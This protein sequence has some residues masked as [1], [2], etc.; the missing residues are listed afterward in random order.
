MRP[1]CLMFLVGV[2]GGC[3][4]DP[5]APA[6]DASTEASLDATLDGADAAADVAPDVSAPLT[7]SCLGKHAV[8]G[9]WLGDPH[10]CLELYAP[11]MTSARQ[12][13]FAPN[14][15]LFVMTSVGVLSLFDS[16]KDGF[17]GP[18]ESSPFGAPVSLSHGVAFSADYKYLYESTATTV[19]RW[20][21]TTGDHVAKGPLETVIK[22]MPAG[23][24]TSRT[25]VFDAQGRLYVNVGSN[26]DLDTP[27]ADQQIRGMVRRFTIPSV[28]PPGGIDYFDGEIYA[29]GMRNEV[30]LAF[31]A[32]GRMW[33]VENGCDALGDPQFGDITKDN[34]AE[35]INQLD[36]KGSRYFGFP[37]CYTEYLI[38]GGLGAGTQ[39]ATET[40]DPAQ[41]KT[42]SWCR[43]KTNNNSPAGAMQGHWAPLGI[44]GYAGT[45]LPWKGDLFVT[46]HGSSTRNP[47]TGRVI[48]R[49]H[50]VGDKVTTIDVLVGKDNNGQLEQGTWASRPVDIREG[51]DGALYVSD[52]AGGNIFRLGYK[53]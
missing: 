35:E 40:I 38:D 24:H 8:P 32:Q 47:P 30:G 7:N 53:P 3:A 34:P 49:A 16:D 25:L 17:I 26:S 23:G 14:G 21:Y 13:A 27:P 46:S 45:S 2:F 39:W 4:E 48:A 44:S 15:D 9:V 1:L 51:P 18:T 37:V 41:I 33:G 50:L 52:D 28:I 20:A 31:D 19:S 22:N 42:D 12:M 36:A 11:S 43:D 6:P 10:L 29:W 5:V